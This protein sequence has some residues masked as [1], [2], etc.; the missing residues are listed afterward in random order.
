MI[1]ISLLLWAAVMF[2]SNSFSNKYTEWRGEVW[3]QVTMVPKV[4]NLNNL[5]WQ[6]QPFALSNDGRKGYC[7]VRECNHAQE[8]HTCHFCHF[9]LPCLQDHRLLRSW[10][11]VT[12]ST[13]CNDFSSVLIFFFPLTFF[14]IAS[15]TEGLSWS[16]RLH[17][18]QVLYEYQGIIIL[19]GGRGSGGSGE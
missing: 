1:L 18:L 9:F 4:L 11:F 2:H 3:G 15:K 17:W 10:N 14:L 7:F 5:S 13:W 19:G 6:R 12:L 16:T 8:S